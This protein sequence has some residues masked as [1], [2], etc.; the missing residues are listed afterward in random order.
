MLEWCMAHPWMTFFILL[1][2]ANA[3]GELGKTKVYRV[4][5]IR[6]IP[7]EKRPPK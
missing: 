3:I 7:R 5:S 2:F 6:P 4:R 1:A